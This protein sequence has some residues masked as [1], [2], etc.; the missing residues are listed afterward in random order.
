[1]IR[2][3]NILMGMATLAH[4]YAIHYVQAKITPTI[5]QVT[6]IRASLFI[7]HCETRVSFVLLATLAPTGNEIHFHSG[8][9]TKTWSLAK[10]SELEILPDEPERIFLHLPECRSF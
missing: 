2:K 4:S 10:K 3:K 8:L 5:M 6:P 7:A 1:M 9:E